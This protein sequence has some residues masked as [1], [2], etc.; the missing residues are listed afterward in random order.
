MN[1]LVCVILYIR[2][3]GFLCMCISSLS[4][5]M[6]MHM[7]IIIVLD[8]DVCIIDLIFVVVYSRNIRCIIAGLFPKTICMVVKIA[9]IGF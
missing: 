7:Y 2:L 6:Y 9:Q 5:S 1:S 8:I 3:S 4:F